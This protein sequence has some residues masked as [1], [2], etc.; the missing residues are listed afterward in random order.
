MRIFGLYLVKNEADVVAESLI[1]ASSWC[2]KVFVFDNGS[3]D[4]T[5]DLIQ[6]LARNTPQVVPF[7]QDP[8]PFRDGLRSDI[9]NAYRAE[10]RASDWWCRLDA[11]EFYLDDPRHFL[12]DVPLQV[13]IV[14]AALFSYYFTDVDAREY[15]SDPDHYASRTVNERLRYYVNHWSEP[16]LFRHRANLVWTR[17]TG[18]PEAMETR[19]VYRR[20]IRVKHF[21]YRSPDQ[22]DRRLQTR[23]P[24]IL[25][26]EFK[27]EAVADW[28]KAVASVRDSDP[29]RFGNPDSA[30]AGNHWR[31]RVVPSESLDFDALDGRL[32]LNDDLM[33]G[34]PQPVRGL[35]RQR[36]RLEQLV[37]RFPPISAARS[38]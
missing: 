11:D 2:D 38:R 33:P 36:V 35:R 37:K 22:I 23:R 7:K 24:A 8:A 31:E 3:T 14:W 19:A 6:D 30:F 10:A 20:R 18:F 1:A 29:E 5:W 21:P 27:H 17:R 15:D 12:L 16:R 4:G 26:G 28:G 25:S 13:D 34:L 32:V 9:F